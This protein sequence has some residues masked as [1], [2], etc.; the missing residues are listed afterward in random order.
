VQSPV[1]YRCR[2]CARGIED[3]FFTANPYDP[4]I[5]FGVCAGLNVI[6]AFAAWWTGAF[7]LLIVI[8]A[9]PIGGL[10]SEVALRLVQKRRGRQSARMAAAG[11]IVGGLIPM[12]FHVLSIGVFIPQFYITLFVYAGLTAAAVYGRFQMRV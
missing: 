9:F 1:G 8:A 12:L 10:I 2:E 11:A 7:L 6:G 4:W 5:I 3:T